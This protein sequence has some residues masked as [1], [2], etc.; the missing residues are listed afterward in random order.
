M[1]KIMSVFENIIQWPHPLKDLWDFWFWIKLYLFD[2]LGHRVKV[3]MAYRCVKL[4]NEF[5]GV[6]ET[7][8]L[9]QLG[10]IS[11]TVSNQI[12]LVPRRLAQ[13]PSFWR[14]KG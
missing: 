11:S 9:A 5:S 3:S 13:S 2:H 1:S 10:M 6:L 4:G 14:S 7:T 12:R 8:E